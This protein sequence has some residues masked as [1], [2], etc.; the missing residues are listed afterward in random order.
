MLAPRRASAIATE[1]PMP[2]AE[3]V[4]IATL[5]LRS[6]SMACTNL[7]QM[8]SSVCVPYSP[9]TMPQEALLRTELQDVNATRVRRHADAPGRLRII[10]IR[11]GRPAIEARPRTSHRGFRQYIDAYAAAGLD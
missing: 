1:A 2:V 9:G 3:P 6:C 5:P 4:T 7:P 8:A 10:L 11:H